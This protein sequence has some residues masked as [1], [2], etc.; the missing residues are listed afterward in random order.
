[1]TRQG[2]LALVLAVTLF[3][4][5]DFT[6]EL[7]VLAAD[8]IVWAVLLV[9]LLVPRLSVG[10]VRGAL[11]LVPKDTGHSART[12]EGDEVVLTVELRN[13]RRWPCVGLTATVDMSAGESHV[14]KLKFYFPIITPRSTTR[15]EAV[16]TCRR[17][18]RHSTREVVIRSEAPFGLFSRSKRFSSDASV[19][20]L[21]MPYRSANERRPA[22]RDR[23]RE[24]ALPPPRE[25]EVAGSRPYLVGDPARSIHWRASA[26]AGRILT[27]SFTVPTEDGPILIMGTDMQD[28]NLFEDVIRVAAGAARVSIGTGARVRL[29][30]GG[31]QL[32]IAWNELLRQLALVSTSTLP[33]IGH[34]LQAVPVG[35]AI[36]AV[37]PLSDRRGLEA[38]QKAAPHAAGFSVWVLLGPGDVVDTEDTDIRALRRAATLVFVETPLDSDPDTP[39]EDE[40][41]SLE[42]AVGD[43]A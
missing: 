9:S 11:E 2:L 1:M 20:V 3:G 32:E 39:A 21:P 33:P 30:L 41:A 23:R 34:S 29:R 25:G 5:A 17:F 38:L 22:G 16:L 19:L 42:S 24:R 26:R 15:L 28:E 10:P 7:W 35:S 14:E 43:R 12:M 8:S 18:G 27:K 36:I 31:N 13:D 4:L 6:G 37:L 40:P